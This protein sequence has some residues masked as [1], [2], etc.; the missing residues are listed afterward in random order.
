MRATNMAALQMLAIA[1]LSL[2]FAP[3]PVSPGTCPSLSIS[4]LRSTSI[5]FQPYPKSRC[6]CPW[7]KTVELPKLLKSLHDPVLSG[8]D[9]V[10]GFN[11]CGLPC[12]TTC[13]PTNLKS[14]TKP[15]NQKARS[16]SGHPGFSALGSWVALSAACDLQGFPSNACVA[17]PCGRKINWADI[18]EHLTIC[19]FSCACI[20]ILAIRGF[21]GI[22][23][24]ACCTAN[25][26][27]RGQSPRC[28]AQVLYQ[29]LCQSCFHDHS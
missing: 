9:R 23:C 20:C 12:N 19:I 7:D 17:K 27:N 13:K 18:I 14:K 24:A 21:T 6:S 15:K 16:F 28:L 8:H 25:F 2:R 29:L 22:P 26:G 3:C 11:C 1:P 10:S 5:N 4:P